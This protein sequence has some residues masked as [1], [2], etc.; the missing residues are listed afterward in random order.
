M[1]LGRIL[2]GLRRGGVVLCYHN[3]V[4]RGEDPPG[5]AALHIGLETFAEQMDF[6]TEHFD[7]LGLPELQRRLARGQSLRGTAAVTFDD[8]YRGVAL[9]ALPL[10]R[11]KGLPATLFVTTR[12]SSDA[13]PFWWDWPKPGSAALDP[14]LR[15]FLLERCQGDE[16]RIAEALQQ[17]PGDV[18]EGF[19][20]CSWAQLRELAGEGV[21]IGAH[22]V[23]HRNLT[24]LSDEEVFGELRGNA[25]DIERELGLPPSAVA[26]PYGCWDARVAAVAERAGFSLGFTLDGGDLVPGI[27]ALALPRINVPASMGLHSFELHVS[28]LSAVRRRLAVR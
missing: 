25:T 17:G 16:R 23:T 18:S 3:V 15:Q 14:Q 8:G 20:P 12:G 27:P 7:V 24:V 26:Y 10:L 22:S 2:R 21:M 28:G 9:H 4:L 13:A 1:G 11:R 5:D 19:R 6:L